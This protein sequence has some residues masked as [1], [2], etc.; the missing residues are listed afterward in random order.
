MQ[1]ESR[2]AVLRVFAVKMV[3]LLS[4]GVFRWFDHGRWHRGFDC[5][6][7]PAWIEAVVRE[8]GASVLVARVSGFCWAYGP[9][10]WEV[11][12]PLV[13]WAL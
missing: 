12:L 4:L 11:E 9:C 5:C 2:T 13:V 7:F 1:S 8:S 6:G 3:E 10:L